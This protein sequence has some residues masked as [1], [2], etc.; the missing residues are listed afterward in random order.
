M[1][2]EEVMEHVLSDKAIY[3][4]SNGGV[5]FTG[6]EPFAQTEFLLALLKSSKE[7]GLHTT[8]ETCCHAEWKKIEKVLAS[9]DFVFADLKVLDSQLHKKFT[10]VDNELILENLM[11]LNRY[12]QDHSLTIAIRMPVVPGMNDSEEQI[13]SAAKWIRDHL[14]EVSIFQILEYHRLGRSKYKNIGRKYSL[15]DIVSPSGEQ[16]ERLRE[17]TGRYGFKPTYE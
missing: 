5:T 15:D 6:G 3:E 10:G 16:M 12:A 11:K 7:N 2:V 1:T 14:S 9:T 8:I 13:D 4:S 17:I